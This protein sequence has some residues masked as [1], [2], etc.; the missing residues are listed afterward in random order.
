MTREMILL[1]D[2]FRPE[3]DGVT[4]ELAGRLPHHA[5]AL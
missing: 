1:G 4:V 5:M 3:V 2:T